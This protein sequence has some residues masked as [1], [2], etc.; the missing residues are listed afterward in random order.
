MTRLP[1]TSQRTLLIGRTGSGK[2][3]GGMWHLSNYDLT[4]PWV[5]FNFKNDEHIESIPEFQ[6][7]GFDYIPDKKAKGVYVI[8]VL[9]E[10][11]LGTNK[12]PSA[13]S[14]YIRKIWQRQNCG[15]YIDEMY[16]V[17]NDPNVNLVL[18]Q[19]RSRRV[20]CI[21][22]TQR[23]TWISRYCFS[24]ASFIQCFDLIDERDQ[25]SVEGF[26][27][28]R[29]RDEVPLSDHQS[30]YFDVA[31]KKLVRLQPVPNMDEIRARFA[32]KLYRKRVF[33]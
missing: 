17:G 24:E 9:P 4:K 7:I 33:I 8:D 25:D 10:E 20:P 13:F 30:F 18:T 6:Q 23:P 32:E 14:N 12:T 31:K 15:I 2:T 26:I 19:G 21:I 28:F 16:M 22:C 1:D 3:V 5:V 11:T 27:P 29:W